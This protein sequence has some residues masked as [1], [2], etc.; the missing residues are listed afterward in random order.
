MCWGSP[1]MSGEE[2]QAIHVV[3]MRWFERT[4]FHAAYMKAW[5]RMV[6]KE[7]GDLDKEEAEEEE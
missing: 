5:E 3:A 2:R 6:L 4:A 7:F 1:C